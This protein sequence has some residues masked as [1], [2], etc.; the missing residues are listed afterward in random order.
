[1]GLAA[2]AT[3]EILMSDGRTSVAV[4]ILKVD[5]ERRLKDLNDQDARNEGFETRAELIADLKRYYPTVTD[6]D[7]VTVIYFEPLNSESRL[8]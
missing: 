8:F 6:E 5:A 1:M 2:V 3:P 4:R 7:R